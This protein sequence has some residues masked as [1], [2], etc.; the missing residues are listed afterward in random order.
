MKHKVL[1]VS[2]TFSHIRNFHR[3]YLAEFSRR[4]WQADIACGGPSIPIP[5]A[6]R[7]IEVPFEKSMF[8]PKNFKATLLLR[9][10]IRSEGYDLISCHTALAAFFVRLA[11]VGL[12][13]R[14]IIVC[15]S[16]G[17]LFDENT[18]VLK[19]LLLS[20]AE[21][22]MA[23]LTDLLMTMNEWDTRYA[24][25]HHLGKQV[26]FIPGMGVNFSRLTQISPDAGQMLREELGLTKDQFLIIYAAEFSA[27]KSQATLLR[28]LPLL[29]EHAVLLLPGDGILLDECKQLAR[30]LGIAHRVI[31]PGHI[32]DMPRWYAAADATVASSRI[33][34]L[35]F[36]IMEAMYCGLPV[37]ASAV[38]GQTD[39]IDHDRTGLLFPYGDVEVC[40]AQLNRLLTEPGLAARLGQAAHNSMEPYTLE[41]VLP[42]IMAIY[43]TL[44]PLDAPQTTSV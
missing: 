3:P 13:P 2:S 8:S 14:P 12:R 43:E 4:G 21:K 5:E 27:R 16:H 25:A 7:S 39:L 9:R 1:F 31:F 34:G 32:S 24:K 22:L 37:V 15:T 18:S 30:E 19:R 42:Q 41:A 11:V 36:N 40:A 44:V 35:P 17:Y 6:C 23:P 38:K 26:L 29:P 10:E 33:E 20:S 28:A